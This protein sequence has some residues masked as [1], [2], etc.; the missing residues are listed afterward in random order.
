MHVFELSEVRTPVLVH[1]ADYEVVPLV[2]EYVSI[3]REQGRI[4]DG[5]GAV[6][7][8]QGHR[9]RRS[10]PIEPEAGPPS[11]ADEIREPR[12]AVDMCKDQL[13]GVA[14]LE[15]CKVRRV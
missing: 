5:R 1:R 6:S 15:L 14:S 12:L 11:G 7:R 2:A 9:Q 10:D 13:V 4:A 3:E 8:R